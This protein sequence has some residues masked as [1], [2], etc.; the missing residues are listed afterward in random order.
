M[1]Q[2]L[3]MMQFNGQ[4]SPV[5]TSPSVLKATMTATSCTMTTVIGADGLQSSLEPAAGGN[6]TIESDVTFVGGFESAV[7]LASSGADVCHIPNPARQ[8]TSC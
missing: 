8:A 3:Y 5:G 6:A 4:V 7:A 1:T 2:I